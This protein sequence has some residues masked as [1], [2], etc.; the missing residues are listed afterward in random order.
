MKFSHLFSL[1][2]ASL[3][4]SQISLADSD[5]ASG[6]VVEKC[7]TAATQ[8]TIPNGRQATEAEMID[9]QKA[10]KAFLAE[11]NEYIECLNK[12]EK[13]WGDEATDEQRAVIVLFNNKIV[14]DQQAVADLFNAAVRAF[15]G[16]N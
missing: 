6:E 12:L 16:K 7:G 15:K 4:F 11:G 10:M 13:S 9:A 2:C 3:L 8:P 5:S 1:L 14:D